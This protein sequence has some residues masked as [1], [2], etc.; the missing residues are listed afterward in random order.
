MY[1]SIL[2]TNAL[3]GMSQEEYSLL[4]TLEAAHGICRYTDVWTLMELIA[5]LRRGADAAY[6]QCRKAVRRCAESALLPL[7]QAP[8]LVVPPELQLSNLLFDV[9]LPYHAVLSYHVKNVAVLVELAQRIATADDADDLADVQEDILAVAEHVD[10]KEIWFAE[11]FENLRNQVRLSTVSSTNSERN[12]AIRA[13]T[14]SKSMMCLDAIALITR[15]Y[16][17]AG[18]T[19][20]QTIPIAVINRVLAMSRAGSVAVGLLLERIFCDNASLDKPRIRN[21]LWDQEIAS[22]MGSTIKGLPVVLVT[23][24]GFFAEVARLAGSA[25]SVYSLEKYLAKLTLDAV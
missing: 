13:F 3:R 1:V 22:S 5:H 23:D 20:P 7:H 9:V 24:D 2:D 17:Q 12:A 4:T 11:Y 15:T 18:V 10:Q 19:V 8:R 6:W 14:R 25:P 21:L 16:L